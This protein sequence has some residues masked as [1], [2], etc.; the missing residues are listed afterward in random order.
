MD[1]VVIIS[2][3][4]RDHKAVIAEKSG[5]PHQGGTEMAKGEA[6]KA[7]DKL[8]TMPSPTKQNKGGHA[9]SF[10]GEHSHPL[11]WSQPVTFL[12]EIAKLSNMHNTCC[13]RKLCS[14][15]PPCMYYRRQ[16]SVL[17]AGSHGIQT[18]ELFRTFQDVIVPEGPAVHCSTHR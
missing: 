15:V 2:S 7:R 8:P 10:I 16:C 18:T 14:L 5:P 13:I 6:T 3:I 11:D 1:I 12:T 4:S 9:P 17:R